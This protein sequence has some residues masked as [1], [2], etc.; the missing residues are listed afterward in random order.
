[1][2]GL[3]RGAVTTVLYGYVKRLKRFIDSLHHFPSCICVSEKVKSA[4]TAWQTICNVKWIFQF[5]T[6]VLVFNSF[7]FERFEK[8]TYERIKEMCPS[9]CNHQRSLNILWIN[10][11]SLKTWWNQGTKSNALRS[12]AYLFYQKTKVYVHFC[13]ILYFLYQLLQECYIGKL[14]SNSV[15]MIFHTSCIST[16]T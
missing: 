9:W 2:W 1:M 15:I 7:C 6:A 8:Y 3:M 10:I 16:G 14:I 4:S 11:L 13:V 5:Y 12:N